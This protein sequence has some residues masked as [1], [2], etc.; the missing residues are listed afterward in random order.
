MTC[1]ERILSR[2]LHRSIVCMLQLVRKGSQFLYALV[3]QIRG[4]L[5]NFIDLVV[6]QLCCCTNRV[7]SVRFPNSGKRDKKKGPAVKRVQTHRRSRLQSKPFLFVLLRQASLFSV[8]VWETPLDGF[9][10][11]NVHADIS[12]VLQQ[13]TRRLSFFARETASFWA[14]FGRRGL[15]FQLTHC[16][17]HDLA[18]FLDLLFR[19]TSRH[20][21][22]RNTVAVFALHRKNRFD[23]REDWLLC[24]FV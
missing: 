4:P 2:T 9:R 16:V 17:C 7:K 19:R 22:L 12:F 8:R 1:E 5:A 14:K 10:A 3:G 18:D 24:H 21:L 11:F 23:H 20:E 15:C 13:R 6:V